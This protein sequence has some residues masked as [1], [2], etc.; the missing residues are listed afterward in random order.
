MEQTVYSTALDAISKGARWRIDLRKRTLWVNG[1]RLVDHG[2]HELVLGFNDD[3]DTPNTTQDVLN[4]ALD[5]YEHYKHSIPSERSEG[6]QRTYFTALGE[7]EL[8][9]RD[10][11][12]GEHRDKAQFELEYFILCTVVNGTFK[13]TDDLGKW[14]WQ[15]QEDK[16]FVILREWIEP[17]N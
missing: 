3:Y 10:M 1:K 9:D 12:Y 16:D 17:N 15:S 2:E 6:R 8:D 5:L 14:F 13:W 11:L 7:S 4:T